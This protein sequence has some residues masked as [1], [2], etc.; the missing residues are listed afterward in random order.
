MRPE[1]GRV[2]EVQVT[3][4]VETEEGVLPS[5]GTRVAISFW[6]WRGGSRD[7]DDWVWEGSG[8]EGAVMDGSGRDVCSGWTLIEG[9][10]G[11]DGMSFGELIRGN[12]RDV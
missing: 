4:E 5:Q 1:M 12:G 2:Q 8:L 9:M 3:E 10:P 7:G 6:V 11:L